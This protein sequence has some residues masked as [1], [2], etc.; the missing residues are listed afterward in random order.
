LELRS[1]LQRMAGLATL[2]VL[3]SLCSWAV[4]QGD[5]LPAAVGIP[6]GDSLTTSSGTPQADSLAGTSGAAQGDSL[7]KNS[8]PVLKTT[9]ASGSSSGKEGLVNLVTT[10]KKAKAFGWGEYWVGGKCLCCDNKLIDADCII[11][12]TPNRTERVRIKQ[13]IDGKIEADT[14]DKET[15][16]GD[17]QQRDHP[18]PVD[19]VMAEITLGKMQD[20]RRVTVYTMVDKDKQKNYLPKCELGYV[21]Q[22]DRLQWAG[23]LENKGSVDHLTFEMEKPVLTKSLLIK[24]TGGRS[25]ITEVAIFAEGTKP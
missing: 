23:K 16:F 3:P 2:L 4:A 17:L 24:A 25:R 9:P 7:A 8:A 19:F 14:G 13:I 12:R 1:S 18:V 5:S 20:I 21:D 11:V 22:F 6:Q 10:D 15:Y